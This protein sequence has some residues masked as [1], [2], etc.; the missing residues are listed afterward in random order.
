MA[1]AVDLGLD[2]EGGGVC[3]PCCS[4]V[5]ACTDGEHGTEASQTRECALHAMQSK[6]L[7]E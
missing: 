3:V 5:D 7:W 1:L 2:G 4:S 6:R